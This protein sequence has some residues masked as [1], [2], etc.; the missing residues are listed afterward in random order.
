M[1]A[2]NVMPRAYLLTVL[3]LWVAGGIGGAVYAQNQ[4]I[5]VAIA[6]CAIPALLAELSLYATLAFEATR[7]IW[8]PQAVAILA[9]VPYVMYAVPAGVFD[10]RSLAAIVAGVTLISY[11]RRYAPSHAAANVLLLILIATP[12]LFKAFPLI[13][14]RPLPDVRLDVL[15]QLLWIRTALLAFLAMRG[16]EGIRFGFWPSREEW[17][18]GLIWYAAALA[19]VLALLPLTGFARFAPPAVAW[20]KLVGIAAGTFIGI[21]WVVALSEEFFFRGLLQQWI[22]AWTGSRTAGLLAASVT[23]GAAHLGFRQFPNWEFALLAGVSGIFYGLAFQRGGGIR[24][25][26]VTHALLVTTWRTLF[27]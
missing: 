1:K 6:A 21:L 15:G 19:A 9:P 5:P 23:F 22:S 11:W 10:W 8:T 18:T 3:L 24:S 26:M 16:Q 2:A 7:R 25:A 14:A 13:Y 17:R 12:L 27:R 4:N 20:W